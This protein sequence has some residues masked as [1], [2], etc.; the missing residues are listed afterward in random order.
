MHP[1]NG[2]TEGTA[3]TSNPTTSNLMAEERLKVEVM[4]MLQ[5]EV[6]SISSP[7]AMLLL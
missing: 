2:N 7:D 6:P 1:D 5:Q 4:R 3:S